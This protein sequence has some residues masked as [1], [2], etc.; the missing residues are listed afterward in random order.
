LSEHCFARPTSSHLRAIDRINPIDDHFDIRLKVAIS[1]GVRSKRQP[2]D[3][4][5]NRLDFGY[6]CRSMSSAERT[7][8][9]DPNSSHVWKHK[10]K[11]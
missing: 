9:A 10:G 11:V 5:G 6:R 3:K 7:S 2:S 8:P 4:L 1:L